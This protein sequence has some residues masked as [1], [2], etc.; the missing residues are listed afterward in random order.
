M[1]ERLKNIDDGETT[2]PSQHFEKQHYTTN[3]CKNSTRL[4]AVSTATNM[5][6]MT[7]FL[8][9]FLP[10]IINHRNHYRS[11]IFK[12]KEHFD[13]VFIDI[14]YAEN[15]TVP[16]KFEPQSLHWSH[17]QVTV[18]PGILKYQDEKSYHPYLSEDKS[19]SNIL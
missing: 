4:K 9:N 19:M 16:V 1:R 10:K 18:H 11:T 2:V 13:S 15:L 12:V 3:N 17:E 5:E 6:F 14:G 7:E 8:T